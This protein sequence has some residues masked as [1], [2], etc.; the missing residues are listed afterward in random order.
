M[1]RS[2]PRA[3]SG[4][5]TPLSPTSARNQGQGPSNEMCDARADAIR[6]WGQRRRLERGRGSRFMIARPIYRHLLFR[7]LALTLILACS[8]EKAVGRVGTINPDPIPGGR[9][10]HAASLLSDGR[11]MVTGGYEIL[12]GPPSHTSINYDDAWIY[13]PISGSWSSGGKLAHYRYN[14]LSFVVSNGDVVLIQGGVPTP[15]QRARNWPIER[16]LI[17]AGSWTPWFQDSSWATAGPKGTQLPS[18]E[19]FF[20]GGYNYSSLLPSFGGTSVDGSLYFPDTQ[21]VQSVGQM[22][23]PRWEHT[24]SLL[25]GGRVLIVGGTGD[26]SS[27][28]AMPFCEIWDPATSSFAL[29]D[30]LSTGRALH[31]ATVLEDGRVLVVGGVSRRTNP[32]IVALTYQIYDPATGLWGAEGLMPDPRV[33]HT[34][35]LLL[36]GKV[37]IAGGTNGSSSGTPTD[38]TF[39]YEPSSDTWAAGPLLE[40]ARNGPTATLLQDGTV[41]LVA[42]SSFDGADNATLDSVEL[43]GPFLP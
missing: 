16:Y 7:V 11:V 15:P 40:T 9:A 26:P 30:P 43:L 14:H 4:A 34:A 19:I 10:W 28:V 29:A 27:P 12:P 22:T 37:L 18:G 20:C 13:H 5:P 3:Y 1:G 33:N 2:A 38:V 21:I 23:Y 39:L 25:P 36:D 17:R 24:V 41:L 31:T 8:S 6:P 35:T 42:G 32:W